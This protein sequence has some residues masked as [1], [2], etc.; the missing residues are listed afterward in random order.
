ME[1]KTCHQDKPLTE[2]P[3]DKRLKSGRRGSCK[4]CAATAQQSWREAN[5]EREK[6]LQREKWNKHSNKYKEQN[7]QA[8]QDNKDNILAQKKDYY[9][10]I[11]RD[12]FNYRKRSAIVL[13]TAEEKR[14]RK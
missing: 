10:R 6:E 4:L 12:K 3:K 8:Y 1:C 11:V 7:R 5:P 13:L 14:K 2:F 9:E